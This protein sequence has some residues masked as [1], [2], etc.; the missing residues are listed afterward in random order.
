MPDFSTKYGSLIKRGKEEKMDNAVQTLRMAHGDTVTNDKIH[1]MIMSGEIT[2]YEA[3][4]WRQQLGLPMQIDFDTTDLAELARQG[5]LSP[6][7]ILEVRKDSAKRGRAAELHDK[8]L[9]PLRDYD[10]QTYYKEAAEA[11][12]LNK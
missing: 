11:F 8:K 2:Q 6:S 7:D 10:R 5:Y 4:K 12:G 3:N 9:S 1:E